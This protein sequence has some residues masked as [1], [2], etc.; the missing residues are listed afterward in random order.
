[1]GELSRPAAPGD[2][3]DIAATIHELAALAPVTSSASRPRLPASA[4]RAR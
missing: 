2:E 3:A 1:M 4:P